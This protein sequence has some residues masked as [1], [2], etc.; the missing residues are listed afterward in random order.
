MEINLIETIGKEGLIPIPSRLPVA[1]EPSFVNAL[2]GKKIKDAT[3]GEVLKAV[4]DACEKIW[5]DRQSKSMDEHDM[6]Q[7]KINIAKDFISCFGSMT[8]A[9]IGNCFHHWVRG[10]YGKFYSINVIDAGK[11]MSDYLTDQNRLEAVQSIKPKEL[12]SPKPG[13]D[14]LFDSA[15][16]CLWIALDKYQRKTDIGTIAPLYYNFLNSIGLIIYTKAEKW[17]FM[18]KALLAVIDE[19]RIDLVKCTDE[20]K[21]A[22]KKKQLILLLA[23]NEP[24]AVLKDQ[25]CLSLVKNKAKELTLEDW[26]A[27]CIESQFDINELV[28]SKRSLYNPEIK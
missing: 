19:L 4:S 24:D 1:I 15:K 12:P 6:K 11:A 16:A 2:S 25:E 22:S 9:E 28:E 27:I 20:H 3:P 14:K 5:F 10:K 23:A 13:P 21:Q 18:Q 26:F 7:L 8:L 17:E